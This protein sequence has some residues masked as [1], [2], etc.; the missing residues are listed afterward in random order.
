[1]YQRQVWKQ[2]LSN[3]I[4]IDP[5]T[6]RFFKS[7]DLT[8][9]FSL[10]EHT[11]KNPETANIF[12]NSKIDVTINKN[13]TTKIANSE[14]SE[15]I[16][17]SEDK[18]QAMKSLAAQIAKNMSQQKKENKEEPKEERPTPS[19]LLAINRMKLVTKPEPIANK[20]DDKITNDSFADALAVA[21]KTYGEY[22]KIKRVL[23]EKEEPEPKKVKVK[24]KNDTKIDV[25]GQIDGEKV[26]GLVKREIKKKEKVGK[27][28]D[29]SQD[30]YV[31]EKLFARKGV[32]TALQH[33]VIVQSDYKDRNTLKIHYE[34][35]LKADMAL[36]ALKKSRLKNWNW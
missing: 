6:K 22:K 1:M 5:K 30:T 20:I 8:E 28:V 19:E 16:T 17:F 32:H 15:T 36:K 23:E 13:K 21:E 35:K 29:K 12:R 9:L 7:S 27:A 34:A 24:H 33:D 18:I 2:L 31:L 26:E 3:K 10:Q 4:L 25:S 11:D 14:S